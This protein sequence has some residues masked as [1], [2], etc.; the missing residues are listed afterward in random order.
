MIF[1]EYSFGIFNGSALILN[2]MTVLINANTPIS[3]FFNFFIFPFPASIILSIFFVTSSPPKAILSTTFPLISQKAIHFF[4]FYI[5]P[6]FF[7]FFYSSR[8]FC[9]SFILYHN[10]LKKVKHKIK[11]YLQNF[12]NSTFSTS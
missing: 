8:K 9:F 10:N 2:P 4:H 11:F 6:S 12:G 1:S 3:T 5:S 7:Q